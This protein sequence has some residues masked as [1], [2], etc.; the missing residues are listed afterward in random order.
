MTRLN[1]LSALAAAVALSGGLAACGGGSSKTAMSGDGGMQDPPPLADLTTN[2]ADAQDANDGALA[3][4]KLASDALVS[5]MANDDKLTTMEVAG[6]STAAMTA[7]LAIEKA[8]DDAEQAVDNAQ[9]VLDDANA[10]KTAADDIA[11][12][13]PQKASLLEAIDDAIEAAEK[14]LEDATAI[15]DGDAIKDA[16]AEVTG[17]ADA[18]S[19]GT[20]LSIA[21]MVGMDIAMALL[22]NADGGGTGVTHTANTVDEPDD[23]VMDA[24]KVEMDDRVGHT[25][26]EIVGVTTKMRIAKSQTETNE[27][28]AASIAGMTLTSSRTATVADAMEENGLQ[29]AATY[30]GILGTAFCVGSD[31]VVETV[32]NPDD[33]GTPLDGMVKFAG[34]W[35]FTP[36]DAMAHWVK[37]ADGTAYVA[38]TLFAQFGHWLTVDA[39]AWTVNTFAT[40]SAATDYSLGAAADSDTLD[41]GDKAT[42]SGTAAGMSVY[43]TDNA[44]GDGQDINSGRFTASVTLNATFGATPMIGGSVDGFEGSA[45]NE[46]WIVTLEDAALALGGTPTL[47]ARTITTGADG[48]WS[49]EAYGSDDTSRPTGVFGGFTAHFSDG[50]AAGAYATR[51]DDE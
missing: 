12:D 4:G 28:D 38:D 26:A 20:P 15:R 49:N 18:D 23:T 29:V 1:K 3:A 24:L 7:A 27:V 19:Q 6:D 25:W 8:Q 16:V 10:A 21:N 48:V 39:D 14:A 43:K 50:H 42:Y 45:V 36:D 46:K 41:D 35:Y 33:P 22:P 47:N 32:D 31:C 5:A 44:A 30:K 9:A 34:S 11:D 2:F 13:H 37:N 40:S 17:G 51:M